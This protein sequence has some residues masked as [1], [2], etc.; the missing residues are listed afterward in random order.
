MD[1]LCIG[2]SFS[3]D[4]TK[5]LHG[6]AKCGGDEINV[7]DLFIGGCS[8][9]RHYRN[10]L[11]DERAYVLDI[12]GNFSWFMVS[13]K[14]ALLNRPWDV[15]TMQQASHFSPYQDT[16]QPYLNEL[17]A[18]VKKCSPKAKIA[19]HQTWAY[20][21]GSE[22]LLSELG[23]K[24]QADMFSDLKAAY[25]KAAAD[26]GAELIIPS[27]AVFQELIKAG[28]GPVHR[29][30]F[31]A[32]YGIGRYALG[33]IWYRAL[34]KKDITDNTYSDFMEEIPAETAE[35]IKECVMKVKI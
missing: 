32:S 24:K 30:T 12:N 21:E 23:Y 33:L 26:I 34:T 20:E 2:N 29:D 4:A 25:E 15:I 27:G 3:V 1:I 6:I 14:E 31:H 5:Y 8:L 11:S 35:K 16:Y 7:T 9:E 28:I 18:Y 10:M 17:Y 22:R 13:L 19:I